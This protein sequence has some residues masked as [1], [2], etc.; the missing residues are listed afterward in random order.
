MKIIF[1]DSGTFMCI[2]SLDRFYRQ[3]SRKEIS[4]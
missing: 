3:V 1:I 4:L 2:I